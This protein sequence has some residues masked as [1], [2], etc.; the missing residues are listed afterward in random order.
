[1]KGHIRQRTPG[2]WT[3]Q[4]Y[5]GTG[6]D[7]K[8]KYKSKTIHGAK[9]Q[10]EA[11]LHRICHEI[12]TGEYVDPSRLTLAQYL[13]E[14]LEAICGQVSGKTYDRYAEIVHTHFIPQLGHFKLAKIKP[15]N[16]Q[17]YYT[18]A[19][20]YGRLDYKGGLA[21]QTVLHFHRL[22]RKAFQDA[23][24][25]QLIARNPCDS[26]DPPRV[27]HHEKRI[28]TK[29]ECDKLIE[30]A[31]GTRSY[32]PILIALATGMRRGEILALRWSDIDYTERMLYLN[33]TVEQVGTT[34]TI[35]EPKT[36]RSRRT[37]AIPEFL[38]AK[39]KEEQA[40]QAGNNKL[41]R[42]IA[43]PYEVVCADYDG[44]LIPPD[45]LS[46]SFQYV[47]RRAGLPRI[48]FHNLRHT[49]ATILLLKGIH[50]KIVQERLGHTT[51]STT[52]DVYSHILPTMQHAAAQEISDFL[53]K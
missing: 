11:E 14:W 45:Y 46:D 6:V 42:G 19:L 48:P 20:K 9:R 16:I 15:L 34:L 22:L 4:W 50:P 41:L 44:S 26:V 2:S 32:M 30:A 37:I 24:R 53:S 29:E 8:K 3:L 38:I 7:G 43:L 13:K 1:M 39:L 23:V 35:K 40:R 47:C 10:A 12:N 17:T 49:H 51:I 18:A 28:F 33:R 5:A 25:W 36:P 52:L 21:P 27:P 31:A